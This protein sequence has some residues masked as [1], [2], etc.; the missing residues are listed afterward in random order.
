MGIFGT[1]MSKLGFGDD[2]PAEVVAE[3]APADI[4]YEAPDLPSFQRTV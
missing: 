3:A 4:T 1:I 2:K